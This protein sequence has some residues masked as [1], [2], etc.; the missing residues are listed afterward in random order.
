[1]RWMALS[2]VLACSTT[3]ETT[4]RDA[5]R[6][7][8]STRDASSDVTSQD[9]RSD[10][11]D[12][13]PPDLALDVDEATDFG[14]DFGVESCD[15][16]W[17]FAPDPLETGVIDT[18]TYRSTVRGYAWIAL[19]VVGG[20]A[21]VGSAEIV[22]GDGFWTW[23]FP[24]RFVSAGRYVLTFTADMG[25]ERVATCTV[26]VRD[27]GVAP[28]LPTAICDVRVCGD[29]NGVGGTCDRCP[30]RA[31]EGGACMD[32]PSSIGPGGAGAWACLDNASC[33]AGGR[34]CRIWCPGEPCDTDRHPDGCPQGVETCWVDASI[35]D[36]EEACR[37]C[38]RSR[39]HAP[40]GEFACWDDAYNICRYPGDCGMPFPLP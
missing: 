30:M 31:D 2:L 35:T 14:V 6:R 10:S 23:T 27:T 7:D 11:S 20:P 13:G 19:D 18:V 36:Y 1:M 12:F 16:G 29:D 28:P 37:Q 3:I 17:T 33:N 22:S 8:G 32:P 26:V 39:H 4:R 24:V 38:C 25:S 34:T 9:A 21:E 40:T 5:S 15:E